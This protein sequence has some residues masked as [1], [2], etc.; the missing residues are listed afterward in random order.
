MKQIILSIQVLAL[1]WAVV[2]ENS[3]Q[4]ADIADNETNKTETTFIEPILI[5]ET[6]PNEPGELSL[7]LTTDYRRGDGEAVGALPN[8][9]VFYGIV[10]RLGTSLSIP[11]SYTKPDASSHYGLGDIS[12][13]LKYLVVRPGPT[14]PAVVLGLEAVFPTGNRKLGLGAGAYA[15]APNLAL[16]KDFGPFCVQGNFAWAKPVNARRADLWTYGWAVSAPLI[17]NKVYLLA[18]IQ[19]DWGSPNHTTLAPGIKYYFTDKFTVGLAVPV[20]LNKNTE[21]W[22]IVTQFQIE[23]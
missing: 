6:M 21:G 5:E 18:E 15:L 10:E 2:T 11:M 13:S 12:T 16:L 8:L 17:R 4:A 19:G 23:F 1:A 14:V 22:G 7:R 9:Q 3:V 20:G